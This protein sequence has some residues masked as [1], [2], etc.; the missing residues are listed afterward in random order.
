M[1]APRSTRP[2]ARGG[3]YKESEPPT[4]L[5]SDIQGYLCI[6][7]KTSDAETGHQLAKEMAAVGF[8]EVPVSKI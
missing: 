1:D 3:A 4:E 8:Y 5:P 2:R 7:Y 6:S